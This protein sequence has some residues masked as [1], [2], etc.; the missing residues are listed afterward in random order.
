[1]KEKRRWWGNVGYAALALVVLSCLL[2]ACRSS[3]PDGDDSPPGG[4][5]WRELFDDGKAD[6]GNFVM[7]FLDEDIPAAE[8]VGVRTYSVPADEP[9][10]M[11]YHGLSSLPEPV[12]LR[13]TLLIDGKQITFTLDGQDAL[14]HDVMLETQVIRDIPIVISPLD[15]GAHDVIWLAFRNPDDHS[16]DEE[17]RHL[18]TDALPDRFTLLAGGQTEWDTVD[19]EPLA[20]FEEWEGESFPSEAFI[21]KSHGKVIRYWYEEMVSAGQQVDYYIYTGYHEEVAPPGADANEFALLIFLDYKLIPLNVG[22]DRLIRYFS[23]E[24]DDAPVAR[25]AVS[26]VAPQEEGPHELCAMRINNPGHIIDE[27]VCEECYS[28]YA[29]FPGMHQRTLIQVNK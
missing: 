24:P 9:I 5:A 19:V 16:T 1:M 14:L 26:F 8:K 4:S 10:L 17:F 20:A 3:L 6:V 2:P 18:S 12:H 21:S 23:L 13:C 29:V 22:D 7:G 28:S 25:I 27:L 15:E 11:T